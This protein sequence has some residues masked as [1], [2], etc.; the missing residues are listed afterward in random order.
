LS[1]KG[2]TS[3]YIT[4]QWFEKCFIPQAKA[5]NAS[6]KPMLLISDGHRSHETIE[7]REA[8]LRDN[9]H[10]YCIP[11]HTSHRLQTLDVGVFGPLQRAWQKR[12]LLIL[13][14][15]GQSIMCRDVPREYLIART[16]SVT[17]TTILAAWRKAGIK[18]F[19][20]EIFTLEDMA[21]SFASSTTAPLPKSFPVLPSDSEDSYQ[22]SDDETYNDNSSDSGDLNG[23]GERVDNEEDMP[24]RCAEFQVANG[25]HA[26]L[27]HPEISSD[28]HSPLP[29][30]MTPPLDPLDDSATGHFLPEEGGESSNR[31]GIQGQSHPSPCMQLHP[32]S[33]V[34]VY[35]S[36]RQ[37]RSM[38]Q[39][40]TPHS[41]SRHASASSA[42]ATLSVYAKLEEDLQL[43]QRRIQELEDECDKLTSANDKL[44]GDNDAL[45]VHCN[46]AHNI[47]KQLQTQ[48]QVKEV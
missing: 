17:E 40:T 29:A 18:P 46:M 19:N 45:G 30:T 35:V 16:K 14:E 26:T 10:L 15:R 9:I 48:V 32:L 1:D 34:P 31:P 36:P 2:W 8:A 42:P 38:S 4:E 44:M 27:P 41:L 5:R 24:Q 23:E 33:A 39:S 43:A 3:N 11:P 6:G 37:T 20:P 12:S 47:N 13:E 21:P 7:L 22:S 25:N 28:L